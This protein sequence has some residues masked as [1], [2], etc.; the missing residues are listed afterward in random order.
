MKTW[1]AIAL[2]NLT[3]TYII[4]I[5][6]QKAPPDKDLSPT[7]IKYNLKRLSEGINEF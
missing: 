5:P 4:S 1:L 2:F 6:P 7:N 3:T